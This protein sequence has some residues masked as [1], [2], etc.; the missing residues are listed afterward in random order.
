M[1]T[2]VAEQSP[3]KLPQTAHN[4]IMTTA[5]IFHFQGLTAADAMRCGTHAATRTDP[6]GFFQQKYVFSEY[7][8]SRKNRNQ[9]KAPWTNEEDEEVRK[10][11]EKH[12]DKS[13]VLVASFVPNRTGKQIRERWHNQLD[14]NIMKGPWTDDEV[15]ISLSLSYSL[16]LSFSFSLSLSLSLSLNK[17]AEPRP[18]INLLSLERETR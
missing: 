2:L 4:N 6:Y 1:A 9:N 11:V 14:P 12:G 17:P 13:W 18:Y 7:A 8:N 10:L 5:P 3:V 15:N 16:C